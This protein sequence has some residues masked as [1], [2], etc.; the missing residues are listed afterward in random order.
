LLSINNKEVKMMKFINLSSVFILCFL[1]VF[2]FTPEASAKHHRYKSRSSIGVSFNVVQPA[3]RYVAYPVAPA[4]VVVMPYGQPAYV[5]PAYGY[6][7]MAQPVYYYP[8]PYAV[9]APVVVERSYP[10]FHISPSLSF[11]IWR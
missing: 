7:A 10:G 4:P 3:P 6:P 5:H 8:Q 9:A 1:F 11:S 2:G